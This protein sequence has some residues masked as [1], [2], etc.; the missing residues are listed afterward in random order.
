MRKPLIF[1]AILVF[2]A[3]AVLGTIQVVRGQVPNNSRGEQIL[4]QETEGDTTREISASADASPDNNQIN[5]GFI[6]SPSAT[7]YQPDPRQDVCYL[8]WYYL[9]VSASPSYMIQMT[10]MINQLGNVA[11]TQGFF[12]TSM[13]VPYNMMGDGFKVACGPLGAG[14]DPEWGNAYA[15]TIRARDSAALSSANYGTAICP[16]FTP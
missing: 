4:A 13:Y 1:A 6:D 15:Y 5:I 3:V 14:G 11:R 7:C 16:A 9:S 8:N 2:L 10:V 12:Q